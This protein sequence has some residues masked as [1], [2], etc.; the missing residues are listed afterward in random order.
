MQKNIVKKG[1]VIA[2][3]LLFICVS[4]QSIIAKDAISSEKKSDTKEL[5]E[6]IKDIVNNKEIQ[7]VIQK[8]DIRGS[9]IKSLKILGVM[10]K[11][12]LSVI[13]KNEVLNKR[14]KYLSDFPCDCENENSTQWKFPFLCLLLLPV[15]ICVLSIIWLIGGY[16]LGILWFIGFILQCF[17]WN[18]WI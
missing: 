15:L 2:V 12:I 13:E 17:W 3:I 5:L 10:Q 14:I 6:T 7:D 8:S 11:E 1:L 4:F 16:P 18:P 9:W